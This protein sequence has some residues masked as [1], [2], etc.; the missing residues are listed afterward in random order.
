MTLYAQNIGDWML[1][2]HTSLDVGGLRRNL[3]GTLGSACWSA[4]PYN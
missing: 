4:T 1:L 3:L 2:T